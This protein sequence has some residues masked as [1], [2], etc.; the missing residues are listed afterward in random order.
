MT[1]PGRPSRDSL[2]A[3]ASTLGATLLRAKLVALFLGP[4]GMGLFSQVT[5]LQGLGSSVALF[6]VGPA[7][8]QSI[9]AA[10]A[11]GDAE[12]MGRLV[13]GSAAVSM[14]LAGL[15]AAA[16]ALS[17]PRVATML[18]GDAAYAPLL[19]VVAFAVAAGA[20]FQYGLA[21]WN[22]F[23]ATRLLALGNLVASA[24]GILV[25][26]A[27][28]QGGGA[29]LLAAV[30][31]LAAWTAVSAVVAV[32]TLP[33]LLR[34]FGIRRFRPDLAAVLPLYRIGLVSLGLMA[35]DQ[36]ATLWIRTDVVRTLGAEANGLY[37]AAASLSQL[38]LGLVGTYV[39]GYAFA[40]ACE[41]DAAGQAA[42]TRATAVRVAGVLALLGGAYVLLGAPLL[43]VL[44][45]R[46]FLP[47]RAVFPLQ[48]AGDLL[49]G[50]GMALGLAL[51]PA[52]GGLAWAAHGLG[53]IAAQVAVYAILPEWLGL[54]RVA[55]AWTV[56]GLLYAVLGYALVRPALPLRIDAALASLTVGG[57]ALLGA[58]AL[59]SAAGTPGLLAGLA[60]LGGWI[61]VVARVSRSCG[62]PAASP[63]AASA[64]S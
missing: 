20:I 45:S 25:F 27:A 61:A 59:L 17:G 33:G 48:T 36:V 41:A 44:L 49:M 5:L 2:V 28:V 9:A 10:R 12:G 34:G 35:L 8:T 62:E 21:L 26:W 54:H 58:M 4:G 51:L 24:L 18:L 56:R 37:Q 60:L 6:G 39:S 15:L 52:R 38:S 32:A 50:L 1:S 40:R 55:V 46:D 14:A 11:R 64:G 31:G 23:R 16:L 47:A 42:L 19:P 53:T 7:L 13:A 57:L 63:C 3:T 29:S 30:Q 22:A 43:S